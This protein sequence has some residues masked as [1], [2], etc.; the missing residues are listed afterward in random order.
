MSVLVQ[1]KPGQWGTRGITGFVGKCS[2]WLSSKFSQA[3]EYTYTN[4]L[5]K[6]EA[7]ETQALPISANLNHFLLIARSLP[8]SRPA[9]T[10][11]SR[12]KPLT[13]V[14]PSQ[15]GRMKFWGEV[16]SAEGCA[17]TRAPGADC[18]SWPGW[19]TNVDVVYPYLLNTFLLRMFLVTL[20]DSLRCSVIFVA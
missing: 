16:C 10:G 3:N 8:P 4:K 11:T 17:V 2:S 18:G 5:E 13:R 6:A 9:P 1:L 19:V 20:S 7:E 14:C 12:T 15:M